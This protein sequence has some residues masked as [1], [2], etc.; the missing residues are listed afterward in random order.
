[1]ARASRRLQAEAVQAQI[2]ETNRDKARIHAN[3]DS[4]RELLEALEQGRDEDHREIQNFAASM[5]ATINRRY[6]AVTFHIKGRIADAEATLRDLD[7]HPPEAKASEPKQDEQQGKVSK[8][9]A[10]N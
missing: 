8:I 9:K 10:V 7:G 6:E 2:D 1:M 4:F 3:L 5:Q